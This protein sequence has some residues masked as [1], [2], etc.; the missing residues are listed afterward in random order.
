MKPYKDY[1]PPDCWVKFATL[2]AGDTFHDIING[3]PVQFIKIN[4]TSRPT[5]RDNC[6][7]LTTGDLHHFDPD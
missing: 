5:L 7:N 6:V 1:T 4:I 3:Q 2:K